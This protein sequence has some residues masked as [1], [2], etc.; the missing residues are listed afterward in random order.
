[1]E[2]LVITLDAVNPSDVTEETMPYLASLKNQEENHFGRL[3]TG[4]P[5]MKG[6][7]GQGHTVSSS[8]ALLT[9]ETP[10]IDGQLA[11]RFRWDDPAI[12]SAKVATH[13]EVDQENYLYDVI[14]DL[15]YSSLFMNIPTMYPPERISRGVTVS[16]VL[17]PSGG[18]IAQPKQ[19]EDKLKSGDYA[20]DLSA[21]AG[22]LD[23]EGWTYMDEDARHGGA[24]ITDLDKSEL[25]EE[26][27]KNFAFSMAINRREHFIELNKEYEF[28]V[29]AVWIS[30][31][32][33]LRHH[34]NSFNNPS[35]IEAE[36]LQKVDEQ[37]RQMVEEAD[38]DHL[39]IHSDHGFG[40]PAWENNHHERHGFYLVQSDLRWMG[41][42]ENHIRDIY[43]T[44]LSTLN[45]DLPDTCTGVPLLESRKDEEEVKEKLRNMGYGE[46]D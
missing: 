28:D 20:G 40:D 26:D 18:R 23:G 1:M 8:L 19:V 2:T 36:L 46:E 12:P 16:G 29:A 32:D 21:H 30:A 4:F 25:T 44:V 17:A 37:V 42:E 43:P 45:I 11:N 6:W 3:D 9:G 39:I 14:D 10:T 22:S 38:P 35:T 5:E 33:R 34:L 41:A 7:G 13:R 27:I 15:G 31:P 24:Y